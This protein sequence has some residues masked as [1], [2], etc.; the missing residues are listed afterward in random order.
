MIIKLYNKAKMKKYLMQL[1]FTVQ[2]KHNR[3]TANKR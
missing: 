2:V 3:N 1:M